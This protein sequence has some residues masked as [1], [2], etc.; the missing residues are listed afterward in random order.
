[1]IRGKE[2]YTDDAEREGS[3][4]GEKGVRGENRKGAFPAD[5]SEILE[6]REGGRK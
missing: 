2:R 3:E 5:R 4:G 6:E 1:L